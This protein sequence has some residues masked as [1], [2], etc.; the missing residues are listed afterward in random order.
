MPE[1]F[2]VTELAPMSLADIY[3]FVE[4]WHAAAKRS[5]SEESEKEHLD[6]LEDSLRH[7]IRDSAPLRRLSTNPLLCAVICALHRDGKAVLP[8]GRIELYRIALEALLERRDAQR[9]VALSQEL[10]LSLSQKELLL[11]DLAYWLVTNG[12]TDAPRNLAIQRLA[13]RLPRINPDLQAEDVYLYLLERTGLLRE[14]V[15]GRVDFVH[16]TFLR[17]S[18]CRIRGV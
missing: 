2:I 7:T 11:Q 14:P 12:Y 18:S 8:R 9:R 15:A 13:V 17:I 16:R 10:G 1:G 5:V 4:H 3:S 6:E